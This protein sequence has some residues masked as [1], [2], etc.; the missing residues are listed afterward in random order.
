VRATAR[1]DTDVDVDIDVG[2]T[3]TTRTTED[4]EARGGG[5]RFRRERSVG[6]SFGWRG[7]EQIEAN[8]R[9]WMN[10]SNARRRRSIDRVVTVAWR[11]KRLVISSVRLFRLVPRGR[12]SRPSVW[13]TDTESVDDERR[14]G[15]NERS[16]ANVEAENGSARRRSRATNC[17]SEEEDETS[18]RRDDRQRMYLGVYSI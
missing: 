17:A 9:R 3:R 1:V 7:R 13:R 4:R 6:H 5:P 14:D 2:T 12:F 8:A 16:R 18:R 10:D 15:T 11:W